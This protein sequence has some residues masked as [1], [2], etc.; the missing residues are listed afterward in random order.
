[1]EKEKIQNFWCSEKQIPDDS[2]VHPPATTIA[3]ENNQWTS[4]LATL[5]TSI[6]KREKKRTSRLK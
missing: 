5:R 3:K 6:E 4:F 1:M 2:T